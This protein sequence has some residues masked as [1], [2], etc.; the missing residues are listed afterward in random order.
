MDDC[1][2]A[3]VDSLTDDEKENGIETTKPNY[4]PY[5]KGDKD[6]KRWYLET[7]FA[8]AWSKENVRFL[9][10]NSCLLYTSLM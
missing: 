1:A 6:G 10:T 4:V 5:D 8:I 9:K 2:I 3:N 7:P